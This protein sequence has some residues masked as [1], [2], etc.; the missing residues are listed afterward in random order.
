MVQKRPIHE[1]VNYILRRWTRHDR[2]AGKPGWDCFAV[3]EADSRAHE[4]TGE[5]VS[6]SFTSVWP[7]RANLREAQLTHGETRVGWKWII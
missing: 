2:G 5:E 6:A 1:V 3:V 4:R 7:K